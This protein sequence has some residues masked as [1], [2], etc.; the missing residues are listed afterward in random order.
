MV[1]DRYP[2]AACC[3]LKGCSSGVA[4]AFS[5]LLM[6]TPQLGDLAP[7]DQLSVVECR[8]GTTSLEHRESADWRVRG[9]GVGGI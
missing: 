3:R 9:M 5:R 8:I 6:R 2:P 1:S 4:L 7:L